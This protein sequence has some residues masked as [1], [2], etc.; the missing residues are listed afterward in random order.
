LHLTQDCLVYY[1]EIPKN[2]KGIFKK[3]RDQIIKLLDNQYKLLNFPPKAGVKLNDIGSF[4]EKD[5]NLKVEFRSDKILIFPKNN[6]IRST[7]KNPIWISPFKPE[8]FYI[9]KSSKKENKIWIF[10]NDKNTISFQDL[11]SFNFKNSI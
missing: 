1:N 10:K 9:K 5:G 11:V 3:E 7:K 8:F 4:S 6:F 2:W